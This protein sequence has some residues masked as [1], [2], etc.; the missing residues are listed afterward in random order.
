MA[1]LWLRKLTWSRKKSCLKRSQRRTRSWVTQTC[2]K[3]TIDWS[4]GAV[5][6]M[7]QAQALITKTSTSTGS[8]KARKRPCQ[9]RRE[10]L[11][12]IVSNKTLETGWKS[13]LTTMTFCASLKAT[14]SGMRQ[15]VIS[16]ARKDL[17]KWT[18]S[19]DQTTTC[20]T[21]WTT[22]MI[23]WMKSTTCTEWGST[24]DTGTLERTTPT[25]RCL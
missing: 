17:R 19:M 15:E 1:K 4:L 13:T 22:W 2:A 23:P 6:Q 3:S 7:K 11:S 24:S 8:R 20:L 10:W 5:Q 9:P 14:R 18:K 25:T 12:V 16:T 21:E